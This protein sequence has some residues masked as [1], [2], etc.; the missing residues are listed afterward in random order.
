MSPPQAKGAGGG[1]AAGLGWGTG[2][3][4][5][6]EGTGAPGWMPRCSEEAACEQPPL[7]LPPEQVPL[8]VRPLHKAPVLLGPPGQVGQHLVHWAVGHV[9]VDG[10]A[11]LTWKERGRSGKW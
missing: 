9:L 4:V 7:D 11:S 8:P 5:T 3:V 6:G 1:T 2:R 10:E